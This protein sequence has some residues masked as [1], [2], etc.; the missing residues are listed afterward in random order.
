L[1][2]VATLE[3]AFAGL[4]RHLT[5]AHAARVIR[6]HLTVGESVTVAAAQGAAFLS[7]A[8]PQTLDEELMGIEALL[9]GVAEDEASELRGEASA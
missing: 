8:F 5:V 9:V 7:R 4:R 3:P 6:Y 2:A 1:S